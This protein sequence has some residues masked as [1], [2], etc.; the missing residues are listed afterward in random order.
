[1]AKTGTDK[2]LEMMRQHMLNR[3]SFLGGSAALAGGAMLAPI[4]PSTDA[5]AAVGGSIRL[6]AWEGFTLD[7]ELADWRNKNKVTV[8]VSIISAQED[9]QAKLLGGSPVAL[10]VTEV[11]ASYG[12]LYA[13]DLKITT[14]LDPSRLPNYNADNIFKFF[15]NGKYWLIDNVLTALPWIWGMDMPLYADGAPPIKSFRDFLKPEYEGKLTMIDGQIG[16]FDLASRL[17]GLGD[18]YPYVTRDEMASAWKALLPWKKQI[19]TFAASNGDVASLVSS[20]EVLGCFCTWTGVPVETLKSGVKSHSVIPEEGGVTWCDAWF[21][22]K[23]AENV[24]TAYEFMNQSLDPVVQASAAKTA[25]GASVSSKSLVHM[26]DDTKALF[27]YANIDSALAKSPIRPLP[28][29]SSDKFA[30]YDDWMQ[31]WSD[32]KS[33]I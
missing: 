18:K 21:I 26:D 9:V 28:P 2:F 6:L 20:K 30:T 14:P 27:D 10:D 15:Y 19:R 22:P 25:A 24:D 33:G 13:R 11:S 16:T 29:G 4:F 8:N 23:T 7:K 32:F 17:A 5:Y 31:G 3:R 1:M 12:E